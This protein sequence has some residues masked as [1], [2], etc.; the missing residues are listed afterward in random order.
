MPCPFFARPHTVGAD[1]SP[2]RLESNVSWLGRRLGRLL[3]PLPLHGVSTHS[4][5]GMEVA[6]DLWLRDLGF[7]GCWAMNSDQEIDDDGSGAS[8]WRPLPSYRVRGR[9]STFSSCAPFP[10]PLTA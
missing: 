6:L 8:S 1:D 10:L 7:I 5:R 4:K 3:L 9:L 2:R